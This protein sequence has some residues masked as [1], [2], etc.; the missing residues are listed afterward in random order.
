MSQDETSVSIGRKS[1]V[2]RTP[3][4]RLA[5]FSLFR[6]SEE[7]KKADRL[8]S[9]MEFLLSDCLLTETVAFPYL[10]RGTEVLVLPGT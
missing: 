2:D 9:K 10:L 5:S 3:Q 8:L 4:H 1:K 7:N 6:R